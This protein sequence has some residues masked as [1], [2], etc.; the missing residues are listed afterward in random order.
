M[1]SFAS[2]GSDAGC[3]GDRLAT[4]QCSGVPF[5]NDCRTLLPAGVSFDCLDG[6]AEPAYE[7]LSNGHFSRCME[8]RLLF[9]PHQQQSGYPVHYYGWEAESQPGD[10]SNIYPASVCVKMTCEGGGLHLVI[11]S[12][13]TLCPPGGYLEVAEDQASGQASILR[14]GPCPEPGEICPSLSCPEDCSTNGRCLDGK[15]QCFLGYTGA[16][17]SKARKPDP[18][19]WL[20]LVQLAT[21]V[22]DVMMCD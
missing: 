11:G 14:I 13:A 4:A 21:A 22:Q 5:A 9:M 10:T 7:F 6:D 18:F 19:C 20:N 1:I 15:C 17:C 2:Q 16:D 3:T 8:V 12:Q